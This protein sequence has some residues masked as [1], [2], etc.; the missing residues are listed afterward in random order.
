MSTS[1]NSN[2]FTNDPAKIKLALKKAVGAINK[3]IEMLDE[4]PQCNEVLMQVDSAIGSLNSTRSQVIDNYLESYLSEV[5]PADDL[6]KA[7][8][9]ILRLYKLNK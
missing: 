2:Q 3:A 1:Q 5:L 4:C 9:Q 8:S 6:N 7:K